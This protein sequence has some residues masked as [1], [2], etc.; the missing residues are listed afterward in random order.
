LAIRDLLNTIW[1]PGTGIVSFD[2]GESREER[3]K[4]ELLDNKASVML[5]FM[6]STVDIVLAT[7]PNLKKSLKYTSND[8]RSSYIL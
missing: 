8:I 2:R 1:H 7:S 4:E 3:G 6:L 5:V